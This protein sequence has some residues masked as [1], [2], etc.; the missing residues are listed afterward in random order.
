M[1]ARW[2]PYLN[3]DAMDQASLNRC[4]AYLKRL[5]PRYIQCF[6]AA[7]WNESGQLIG[8][9]RSACPD[10]T[11]IWRGYAHD[12]LN[13]ESF[14][15]NQRAAGLSAVQAAYNWFQYRV[16]PFE[17]FIRAH[18]I[19]IM[20]LNEAAPIF[21]APFETECIRLLGESGIQAAAMAWSA[22]TPDLPD[23]QH[24][25]LLECARAM[26]R[27][28]SILNR[29]EY[30]G[31][32]SALQSDLIYR[33]SREWALFDSIG[34]GRPSTVLGEFGI[35]HAWRNGGIHLDA[36]KGWRAIGLSEQ[37]YADWILGIDSAWY[38]RDNICWNLYQWGALSPRWASFNIDQAPAL[39]ERLLAESQSGGRLH[40][41]SVIWQQAKVTAAAGVRLRRQPI[42]GAV[43]LTIPYQANVLVSSSSVDGWY[44]VHYTD[45]AG[46]VYEGFSSAEY[47]QI[48]PAE[49]TK[50]AE[51]APTPTPPAPP[52]EEW[53][54]KLTAAEIGLLYAS[55][56]QTRLIQQAAY[57]LLNYQQAINAQINALFSSAL[58]EL[59]AA[60]SLLKKASLDTSRIDQ[61]LA[62]MQALQN[63]IENDPQSALAKLVELAKKPILEE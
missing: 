53:Q 31:R 5:Q 57:S 27:Y 45:K 63:Q 40:M 25:A 38:R 41:S 21:N 8:R 1:P 9:I 52:P 46:K 2:A 48:L 15:A 13:D 42:N 30:A 61:R 35:V 58:N 47:I 22:G 39:L 50:P 49:P 36:E 37:E 23:Y 33:C 43:D 6:A 10:S 28:G 17:D 3:F 18:K 51:P 34:L 59:Y 24:P 60:Y 56:V 32:T 29:H 12:S 11:I 16:K 55:L 19:A 62:E 7:R 26:R 54:N 4:E 20:L 44:R 14:Y